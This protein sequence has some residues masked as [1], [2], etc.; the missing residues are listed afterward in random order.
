MIIQKTR[1]IFLFGTFHCSW[2]CFPLWPAV[3]SA[4]DRC[5]CQLQVH[6]FPF[7][8]FDK[9]RSLCCSLDRSCG[10][11]QT[12]KVP[13]L[14]CHQDRTEEYTQPTGLYG[15]TKADKGPHG[16]TWA[17]IG[18]YDCYWA[19]YGPGSRVKETAGSK[20]LVRATAGSKHV[21]EALQTFWAL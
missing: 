3:A 17:R 21:R 1:T 6:W 13:F 11:Y 19:E 7:H 10:D 15:P 20:Y 18:F 16:F 12:R 5:S 4:K 8:R 2:L 9:T 14:R